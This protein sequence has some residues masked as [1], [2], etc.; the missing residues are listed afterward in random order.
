MR[1]LLASKVQYMSL[2]LKQLDDLL[3]LIEEHI[4]LE[5]CKEFGKRYHAA[6]SYETVD[7]LPLVAQVEFGQQWRLPKPR[8]KFEQYTYRQAFDYPA[9]MPQNEDSSTC[10]T[11]RNKKGGLRTEE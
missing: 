5:S 4:N 8:D 7:Y 11:E 3:K 1:T 6:L 2:K 10:Y 9:A